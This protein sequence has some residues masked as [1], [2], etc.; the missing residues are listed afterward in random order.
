MMNYA[1]ANYQTKLKI[2][3]IFV[4]KTMSSRRSEQ[5][6]CVVSV[7]NV[8]RSLGIQ[9]YAPGISSLQFTIY[10]FPATSYGF[11]VRVLFSGSF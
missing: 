5:L 2:S 9:R 8:P 1:M 4:T 7:D 3:Y 10:D 11:P 6:C